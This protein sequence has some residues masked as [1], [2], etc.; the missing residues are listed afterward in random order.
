MFAG[1]L[2]AKKKR[3]NISLYFLEGW[4]REN[5][6]QKNWKNIS[7]IFLIYV[8][9]RAGC[10]KISGKKN[11][12]IC[13]IF[14]TLLFFWGLVAGKSAAKKLKSISFM[15]FKLLFFLEGW[16]RENR[17]QKNEQNVCDYLFL[18]YIWL[19][20]GGGKISGYKTEKICVLFF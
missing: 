11:E 2:A 13:F 5:R 1:K 6:R 9:W 10:G 7:F 12:K 17:R 14:W 3:K 19:R 4:S 20:A 18:N 16:S 15:F 8:F